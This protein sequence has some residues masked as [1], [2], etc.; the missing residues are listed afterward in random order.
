MQTRPT[1]DKIDIGDR[2]GGLPYKKTLPPATFF[3][4]NNLKGTA[5]GSRCG[6]FEGEHPKRHQNRYF[7][8]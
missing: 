8:P 5:K 2:G 4:L 7:K 1:Q 6:S 3:R